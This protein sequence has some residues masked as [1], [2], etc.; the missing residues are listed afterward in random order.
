MHGWSLYLA[1]DFVYRP[2]SKVFEVVGV[3]DINLKIKLALKHSTVG[4]LIA[5][6][7]VVG[8]ELLEIFIPVSGA[9]ALVGA[10]NVD[11][12]APALMASEDFAWM[13][14]KKPGSYILIGNGT[15]E[16]SGCFVHNPNYDFNDEILPLGASY[17]V[18]LVEQQL[19][20]EK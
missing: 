4:A 9:A 14:Q 8:S 18:R 3:F 11:T 12:E 16:S 19:P 2:V 6:V 20:A 5:G 1:E 10:E 13:L 17:W 15:G 7:F